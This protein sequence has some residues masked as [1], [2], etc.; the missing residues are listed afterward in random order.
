MRVEEIKITYTGWEIEFTK[1]ENRIISTLAVEKEILK[2]ITTKLANK[3]V[4]DM[5]N[6]KRS[7]E[8][9]EWFEWA[10]STFLSTFKK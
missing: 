3:L 7:A 10:I 8:Y 6:K 5:L 2:K 4:V 1:E 9:I